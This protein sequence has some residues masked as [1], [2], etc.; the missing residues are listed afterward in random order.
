MMMDDEDEVIRELDV[1]LSPD[2]SLHLLQFPLKPVYSDQLLQVSR[3]AHFKPINKKLEL[4][5]PFCVTKT[6]GSDDRRNQ[7]DG[8]QQHRVLKYASS[9]VGQDANL[10]AAIIKNNVMYLSPV[11]STLQMRPSF[12]SMQSFRQE[13]VEDYPMDFENDGA[14]G[15]LTSESEAAGSGGALQQVQLK[16]KESEKAQSARIQ[17]FSYMQAQ[18]G[19]EKWEKLKVHKIGE[20]EELDHVT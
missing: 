18:E 6:K 5:V 9:A 16:R 17:S 20:L 8:G 13:V 3:T 10:A 12:K 14:E 7:S 11:Q 2:L 19:Q 15:L 1:C 4:E